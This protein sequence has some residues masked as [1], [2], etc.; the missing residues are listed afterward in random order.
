MDGKFQFVR[1]IP[2]KFLSTK[3]ELRVQLNQLE[4]LIKF[5]RNAKTILLSALDASEKLAEFEKLLNVDETSDQPTNVSRNSM[6]LGHDAME[7]PV[8]SQLP[9]GCK[10]DVDSEGD[11]RVQSNLPHT[12]TAEASTAVASDRG[13]TNNKFGSRDTDDKWI[14]LDRCHSLLTSN[15]L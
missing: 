11:P 8:L 4:T 13:D 6:E 7:S 3:P 12:L 9:A 10:P 2:E 5:K 15:N 14:H 1:Q